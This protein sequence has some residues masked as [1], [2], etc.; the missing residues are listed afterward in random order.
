MTMVGERGR[1]TPGAI[2][3]VGSVPNLTLAPRTYAL[4]KLADGTTVIG[5]FEGI[6]PTV[7]T[8]CV[9]VLIV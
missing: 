7:V 1:L 2:V 4:L 6:G 8:A 5:S 3:V 9:E